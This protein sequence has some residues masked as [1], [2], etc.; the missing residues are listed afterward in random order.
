MIVMGID[1]D[2]G[3]AIADHGRPREDRILG[4][5]SLHGLHEM[6]PLLR[7]LNSDTGLQIDEVRIEQPNNKHA[8]NREGQSTTA[9]KSIAVNVGENLGKGDAIYYFCLGL[10]LNAI[11]TSPIKNGTKL[12]AKQIE[13]LTNWKARTNEHSRDAIII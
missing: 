5:G 13:S 7:E 8:Y 4:A 12:N 2:K 6:F 11:R 9:M 1:P 10:G 3:W